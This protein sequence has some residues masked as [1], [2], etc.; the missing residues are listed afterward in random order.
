MWKCKY[1]NLCVQCNCVWM[2]IFVGTE[3]EGLYVCV[4]VCQ[5]DCNCVY[6]IVYECESRVMCLSENGWTY[7][8]ECV[9]D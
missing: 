3:C 5:G 1:V 8:S 9:C 4:S 7:E 6:V 2:L